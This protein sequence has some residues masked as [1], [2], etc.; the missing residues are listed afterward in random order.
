MKPE[1][2]NSFLL[3]RSLGE[4]TPELD[5]LLDAYLAHEPAALT[6][7]RA[8]RATVDLA[9]AALATTTDVKPPAIARWRTPRGPG[10]WRSRNEILRLAAVL[11]VGL[12]MG[13]GAAAMRLFYSST[14]QPPA[15]RTVAV[16]A[17]PE[18]PATTSFWSFAPSYR[19]QSATH[20]ASRTY[21]LRWESPGKLPEVEDKR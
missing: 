3:D 11:V 19:G 6:R 9:H 18:L 13:W 12:G 16:G 17:R 20:A 1:T 4:L 15:L 21:H 5:E 10:S 8:Y 14:P 7:A 2:L